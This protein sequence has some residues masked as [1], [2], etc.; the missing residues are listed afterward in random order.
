MNEL[1]SERCSMGAANARYSSGST[2]WLASNS[3]AMSRT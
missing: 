3:P 1:A 2:R